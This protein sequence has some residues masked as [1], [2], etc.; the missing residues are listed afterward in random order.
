MKASELEFWKLGNEVSARATTGEKL[1][2][3]S[4]ME[5]SED[6]NRRSV[7]RRGAITLE[8]RELADDAEL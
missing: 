8:N 3:M 1:E 4:R 6:E 7:Q 2:S 5:L